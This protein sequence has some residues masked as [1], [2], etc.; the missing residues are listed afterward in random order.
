[1][2]CSCGGGEYGT[3]C[4][5]YSSYLCPNSMSKACCLNGGKPCD[6]HMECED[7]DDTYFR[8]E[9]LVKSYAEG[10]AR[11]KQLRRKIPSLNPENAPLFAIN[12]DPPEMPVLNSER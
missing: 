11:I 7:N 9:A 6:Y 8:M 12:E 4:P 3:P 5:L 2:L 10:H 1:M